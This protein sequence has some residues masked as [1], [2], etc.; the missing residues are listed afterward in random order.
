MHSSFC[1][2]EVLQK[3]YFL[4]SKTSIS[5]EKIHTISHTTTMVISAKDVAA[6]RQKTGAGMMDCKKALT[7]TAGDVEQAIDL[8]RK[9]GQKIA[10]D[11]AVRDASEGAV[12]VCV[13]AD[14]TE[15]FL[16]VLNCETDF[17][18]KN[19]CFL[20]LGNTILAAAVAQKPASKEAL[21]SLSLGDATV[22][23]KIV[24]LIGTIGEKITLSAYET[25]TGEVVVS[26]LHT[27]NAL[28]VLVALQGAKGENVS[29]AGKDVAMQIAAMNPVALD[30]NQVDPVTIERERAIISEQVALEG[31]TGVQAEKVS[32]GRLTKFFRENTLLQ[33]PFVKN[34]KVTVE[35]FL[36]GIAA[37][38]TVASFKR[39]SVHSA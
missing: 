27:G 21:C 6:L 35:E 36:K 38:L 29:A 11:R 20:E 25:L 32:Q 30:K 9:K 31:L 26:Y 1:Q 7:E 34:N 18:A 33:Q 2:T 5:I 12:F 16:I 17:V 19:D 10:A 15:A 37:S 4:L 13:N 24:S 14:H 8:L 22:Q 28:G 39:V 3:V 23:E